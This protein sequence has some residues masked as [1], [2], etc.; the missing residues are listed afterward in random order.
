M[1]GAQYG[2][3]YV[4]EYVRQELVEM[5]NGDEAFVY[6]GGLRVYTTMRHDMQEA[7]YQTVTQTLNQQGDPEAS[8]VAVGPEGGPWR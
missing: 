6:G 1:R 2:T 5:F 7:A 4:M 8:I 3:E